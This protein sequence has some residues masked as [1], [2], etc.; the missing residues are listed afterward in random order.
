[1]YCGAFQGF[2][3]SGGSTGSWSSAAANQ[4]CCGALQGLARSGSSTGN[5]SS[6]VACCGALQGLAR[7]GTST[8]NWPSGEANSALVPGRAACEALKGPAARPAYRD[9]PLAR[10]PLGVGTVYCG[11]FQGFVGSGG[12]AGSWLSAAANAACCGAL[13]GLARSGSSTGNWSSAVACCGAL[14]GLARSGTS[15]SNWPSGEA[16]SALVPGRAACEALKGP[17]ARPARRDA[18][19]SCGSLLAR[20]APCRP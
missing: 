19:A 13:Q 6:A 11:A 20:A 5:W 17:A 15:T 10:I 4:A 1:M 9:G 3:G 18:S 14:Q 2:V 8:S 7:S 12:S 16:N